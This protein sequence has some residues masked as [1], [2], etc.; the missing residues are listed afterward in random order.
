[1][2]SDFNFEKF[3]NNNSVFENLISSLKN[4]LAIII[5]FENLISILKNML[6]IIIV[7]EKLI[8]TLKI[9]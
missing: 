4:M 9:S 6:A 1:L 3:A 8:A 2:N 5:V 7:F